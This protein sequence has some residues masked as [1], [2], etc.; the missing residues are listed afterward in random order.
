MVKRDLDGVYFRVMRDGK[1]AAL[2]WTDFV[3][4]ERIEFARKN[5]NEDWLIRMIQIMNEV[6][7]EIHE[8]Y[9]NI[10]IQPVRMLQ[11]KESS[12]TWLRNALFKI[13]AEIRMVAEEHNIVCAEC[14]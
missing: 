9:P 12:K 2:C 3:W 8:A 11:E 6:A 14:E 7:W 10:E 4:E 13:T 5:N 1:G